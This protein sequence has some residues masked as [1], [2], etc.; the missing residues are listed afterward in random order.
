MRCARVGDGRF[1]CIT[2][3]AGGVGCATV[4]GGWC[5]APRPWDAAVA[6]T[7]SES[8]RGSRFLHIYG[9]LL[10]GAPAC[11]SQPAARTHTRS[12]WAAK[13][14]QLGESVAT[15]HAL[16]DSAGSSERASLPAA[17]AA[18]RNLS[19]RQGGRSHRSK[20]PAPLLGAAFAAPAPGWRKGVAARLIRCRVTECKRF[21]HCRHAWR[22]YAQ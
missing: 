10:H 12:R 15:R 18:V 21:I 14:R 20:M 5:E 22:S 13:R 16:A 3:R 9:L 6:I 2:R 1:G 19:R 17:L 11:R 4:K 7:A 8:T